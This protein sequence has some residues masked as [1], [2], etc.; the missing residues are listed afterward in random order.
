MGVDVGVRVRV[1]VMDWVEVRV[2]LGVRVGVRPYEWGTL[3][4]ADP[5]GGGPYTR[6]DDLGRGWGRG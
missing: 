5:G 3:G 6:G 2:R 4:V 1:E